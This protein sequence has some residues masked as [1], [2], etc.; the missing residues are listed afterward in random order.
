MAL[1]DING[2]TKNA[3]GF[4]VSPALVC[5]VTEYVPLGMD[6]GTVK[7]AV[8]WPD[9]FIEPVDVI[10]EPCHITYGVLDAVNPEPVTVT[11]W[12]D[13]PWLGLI[14]IVPGAAIAG[15]TGMSPAISERIRAIPDTRR[16]LICM[17]FYTSSL[18]FLI[19]DLLSSFIIIHDIHHVNQLF[20][21]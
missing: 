19:K 21:K 7:Y 11:V 17:V 5:T 20:V 15:I 18:F 16:I 12:P 3:T 6:E 9:V 4:E 8:R 1:S 13:G 14:A 10:C 2:V